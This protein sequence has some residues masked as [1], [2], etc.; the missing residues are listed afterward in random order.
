[1]SS[2]GTRRRRFRAPARPRS[3]TVRPVVVNPRLM[4]FASEPGKQDGGGTFMNAI[5]RDC[6]FVDHMA[7]EATGDVTPQDRRMLG[8]LV[9]DTIAIAVAARRA[10]EGA[11]AHDLVARQPLAPGA[12]GIWGGEGSATRALDAAFLNGSAAEVLDFQEVLLMGRNNGHA[13]VVIVPALLALVQAHPATAPRLPAALRAAF[14]ANIGLMAALGRGHRRGEIGF[15]TTSLGAPVAAALGG[16]CL[17]GLSPQAIR[18]ATAIAACA[19]PAGLLSAMA[20]S[21]GSYSAD[22]DLSV[23][24]SASFAADAVLMAAAGCNG[25]DGALSGPRGW[26]ASYGFDTADATALDAPAEADGLSRYAIKRFPANFGCQAAIR[27]AL[28]LAMPVERIARVDIRVKVSSAASLSTRALPNPLAARFSLPYAVASTLVRRH[29]TLED[30]AQDALQS[31]EVLS[32]MARCDLH[33]D[34]ALEARHQETGVFPAIMRVTDI[35]GRT[36]EVRH[37]GPWDALAEAEVAAAFD[38]KLAA[39]LGADQAARLA[40]AT[41]Q[42]VEGALPQDFAAALV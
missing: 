38:A 42:L 39:L 14:L 13:A 30:F 34:D 32:V 27:C 17:L 37:D 33:G 5:E 8:Q 3:A 6:A 25:P 23:G 36:V 11:C 19:L 2:A 24:W 15:R 21:G 18:H 29:C 9:S 35:D 7:A 16:A 28:D 10:R 40:A 1:M 41:R 12:C 20:P 31:P 26:L 22:K 4:V